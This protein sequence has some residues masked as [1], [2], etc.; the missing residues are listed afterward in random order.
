MAPDHRV[1]NLE[2]FGCVEV[3]KLPTP[4]RVITNA[5]AILT[6]QF[7]FLEC[8]PIDD[9]VATQCMVLTPEEVDRAR[10]DDG[11][12]EDVNPLP[13][14]YVPV[15]ETPAPLVES[16]PQDSE[17]VGGKPVDVKD[18]KDSVN[19][20][21]E[22]QTK[23][24]VTD[25]AIFEALIGKIRAEAQ[26]H[27]RTAEQHIRAAWDSANEAKEVAKEAREMRFG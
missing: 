15:Q 19:E 7:C 11:N 13:H 16:A 10:T 18:K 27:A 22:D 25:E 9:V 17:S 3:C 26:D 6:S 8:K 14:K 12:G 2:A 1:E 23:V 21:L 4:P 5:D 20:R 24:V